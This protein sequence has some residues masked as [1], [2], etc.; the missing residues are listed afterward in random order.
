LGER[1]LGAYAKQCGNLPAVEGAQTTF[2]VMDAQGAWLG[3][4][5]IP[6]GVAEYG[7]AYFGRGAVHLKTETDEG[8]PV[9][10]RV[11]VK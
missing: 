11:R 1:A 5:R 9:I 7:G 8:R 10:I 4:V 2:D 3:T 6:Y